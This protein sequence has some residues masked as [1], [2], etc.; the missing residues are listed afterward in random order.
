MV[1]NPDK[2][3]I[4]VVASSSTF[5][6]GDVLDVRCDVRGVAR[7]YQVTWSRVGYSDLGDNVI[8]QPGEEGVQVIVFLPQHSVWFRSDWMCELLGFSFTDFHRPSRGQLLSRV[9]PSAC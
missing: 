5:R 1:V 3:D 6:E 2:P 7:G 4:E 8:T 9:P